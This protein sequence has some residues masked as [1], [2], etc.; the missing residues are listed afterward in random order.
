MQCDRS[1]N[2]LFDFCL[3]E[4]ARC[5]ENGI[6]HIVR[7]AVGRVLQTK[8]DEVAACF[9]G[10]VISV[11]HEETEFEQFEGLEGIEDN[12]DEL[13]IDVFELRDLWSIVCLLLTVFLLGDGNQR[14]IAFELLEELVN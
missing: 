10:K 4:S 12:V 14:L 9:D 2:S 13:G 11:A 7:N 8:R 3:S 5:Q 6:N 1:Q